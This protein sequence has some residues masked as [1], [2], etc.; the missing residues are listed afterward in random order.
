[1]LLS[2]N[3]S[4]QAFLKPSLTWELLQAPL[5]LA[6]LRAS[7]QALSLGTRASKALRGERQQARYNLAPKL[8]VRLELPDILFHSSPAQP[9]V[10]VV[11]EH[12]AA[13]RV[14]GQHRSLELHSLL[15][16]VQHTQL[17]VRHR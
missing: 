12:T 1:V 15:V 11:P 7:L 2:S 16:Q 8:V 10:P 3:L 13:G 14:Q 9:S 6:S 5:L 4:S 17:V